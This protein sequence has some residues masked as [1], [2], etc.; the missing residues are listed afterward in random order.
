MYVKIFKRYVQT[1]SYPNTAN[2]CTMTCRRKKNEDCTFLPNVGCFFQ[3]LEQSRH[4]T[5]K[6]RPL[7][8]KGSA[9]M[10]SRQCGRM[11]EAM[12]SVRS[13]PRLCSWKGRPVVKY[14]TLTLKWVSSKP[15]AIQRGREHGSGRTSMVNSCNLTTPIEDCNQATIKEDITGGDLACAL[16]IC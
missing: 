1:Y 10:C 3:N 11:L 8:G 4:M 5:S 13:I 7:L 2:V 9:N 16:V 12:F 15:A 14:V 6:N